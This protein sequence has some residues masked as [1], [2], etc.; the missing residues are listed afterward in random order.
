MADLKEGRQRAIEY[1]TIAD[2]THLVGYIECDYQVLVSCFGEPNPEH[3]D[4]Y[5][6]DVEWRVAQSSLGYSISIYNWKN[7][8]NYCGP[9]GLAVRDI[10]RW[11]VGGK[12]S[13]DVSL[14]EQVL[15][16]RKDESFYKQG[17]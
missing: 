7:G 16:T 15:G 2:C 1:R 17:G 10:K 11:N 4:S 8:K 12:N 9:D 6:T 5:K 14:I 3:C 13:S